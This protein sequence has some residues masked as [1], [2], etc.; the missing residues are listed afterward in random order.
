[1]STHE[2]FAFG[3]DYVLVRR[4]PFQCS[5]VLLEHAL[6]VWPALTTPISVDSIAVHGK[7]IKYNRIRIQYAEPN[8][9]LTEH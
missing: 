2:S 5:T 1:M 7:H 9:K 8:F 4:E 3:L 6:G